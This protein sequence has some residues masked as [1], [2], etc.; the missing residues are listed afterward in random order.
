MATSIPEDDGR[1]KSSASEKL[2][3]EESRRLMSDFRTLQEEVSLRKADITGSKET[4]MSFMDHY[5]KLGSKAKRPREQVA[6]S[7]VGRTLT[8]I[9]RERAQTDAARDGPSCD[10]YIQGLLRAYAPAR[11]PAVAPIRPEEFQWGLFATQACAYFR[12][13]AGIPTM[14]GPMEVVPAKRRATAP[15]RRRRDPVA[16]VVK[17]SEIPATQEDENGGEQAETRANVQLMFCILKAKR[18]AKEPVDLG[19]LVLKH[20][21]FAETVENIFQL[22]F[23]VKEGQT[24]ISISDGRVIVEALNKPTPEQK[25]SGAAR[26]SQF[27]WPFGQP[28]WLYLK[29]K[30]AP[31]CELMPTRSKAAATAP[32]GSAHVAPARAPLTKRRGVS[33]EQGPEGAREEADGHEESLED[34]RRRRRRQ[35]PR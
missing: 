17:P 22:S 2:T 16:D 35:A 18:R 30:V 15:Q 6:D 4:F 3:E 24:S 11:D 1:R 29:S 20:A 23:L 25:D 19:H 12:G 5:N 26:N 8:A 28:D 32:G 21:S 31:E 10:D 9:V 7:G 33:T 14:L 34:S 13:A 27:I